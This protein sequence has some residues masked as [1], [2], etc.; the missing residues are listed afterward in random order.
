MGLGQ[1]AG[2]AVL[3]IGVREG[4]RHGQDVVAATQCGL[5]F[6]Q[7]GR[8]TPHARHPQHIFYLTCADCILAMYVSRGQIGCVGASCAITA[9]Y[10]LKMQMPQ[11]SK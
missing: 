8:P 2:R 11:R 6:V 7:A 9:T 4:G 1:V 3:R 10:F 5:T